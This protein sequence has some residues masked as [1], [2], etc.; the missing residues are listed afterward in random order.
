MLLGASAVVGIILGGLAPSY[1]AAESATYST[2]GTQTFTVPANVDQVTVSATG[3]R[4]GF[5]GYKFLTEP[6][7]PG[8]GGHLQATFSVVPGSTLSITVAGAGG[9]ATTLAGG[10]GGIGGGGSGGNATEQVTPEAAYGGGG[11]GGASSVASSGGAPML[12][13]AGGGGCGGWDFASHG[14]GGND[15]VAGGSGG[16]ALGGQPGGT[17]SGGAGGASSK[18]TESAGGSGSGSQGGAGAGAAIQNGGGGGGGGGYFGGGGGGGVRA[19]DASSGGGGGGSDFFGAGAFN[20][21]SSFGTG[22]G[23]GQVTLT[24]SGGP[25]PA[26][27]TGPQGPAG[28]Q[29]ATGPQGPA[30]AA[31]KIELVACTMITKTVKAHGKTKNVKQKKCTTKLVTGVVKF[32]AAA[33]RA[34]LSRGGRV[35]AVGSASTVGDAGRLALSARRTMH[36]GRYTLTLRTSSGHLITQTTVTVS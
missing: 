23:D 18:N 35:Y 9:D 31:G 8:H 2:P 1:A 19:G 20:L 30:G 34:T 22:A 26:L 4:G 6:C 29:G 15:G 36:A 32:T 12:I 5:D 33:M 24:Y 25:V 16:I 28:P 3:A 17:L 14:G 27:P 11:G 7:T 10:Q 21:S 13:A